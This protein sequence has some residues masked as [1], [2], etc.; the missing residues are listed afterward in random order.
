MFE[1]VKNNTLIVKNSTNFQNNISKIICLIESVLYLL[2]FI[3]FQH[4]INKEFLKK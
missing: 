1:L 4:I 3:L 2:Y